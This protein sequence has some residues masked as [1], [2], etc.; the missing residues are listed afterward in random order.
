MAVVGDYGDGLAAVDVL[1][2]DD[3]SRL[4]GVVL[5][6]VDADVRVP[7]AE[8]EAFAGLL[9]LLGAGE[10][11]GHVERA[12]ALVRKELTQSLAALMVKFTISAPGTR[13][14]SP[15]P[16]TCPTYKEVRPMSNATEARRPIDGNGHMPTEPE[17]PEVDIDKV[18]VTIH[19]SDGLGWT[20]RIPAEPP[21]PLIAAKGK[22]PHPR[23]LSY[24]TW[25][26]SLQ[27]DYRAFEIIIAA[28]YDIWENLEL[29]AGGS[30]P[31]PEGDKF[32]ALIGHMSGLQAWTGWGGVW[33][34]DK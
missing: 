29:K 7:E 32:E 24:A 14:L 21:I 12:A 4:P 33:G 18:A 3:P 26:Y 19:G 2:E 20:I 1:A 28:L 5:S 31:P 25:E 22:C 15:V 30:L 23:S 27:L 9:R 34:A 11:A 16:G 13:D 10:L 17:P 8:A 6:F